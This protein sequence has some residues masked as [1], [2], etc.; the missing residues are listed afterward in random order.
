MKIDLHMHSSYSLDGEFSPEQLAVLCKKSGLQAAALTDH[1]S[2]R[3]TEGFCR[4]AKEQGIFVPG[5]SRVM[6]P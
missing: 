1:N 4:A 2:V 5:E 3:G 6:F